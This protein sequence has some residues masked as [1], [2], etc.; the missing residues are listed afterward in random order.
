ML[1]IFQMGKRSN[2]LGWCWIRIEDQKSLVN[3]AFKAHS[4]LKFHSQ[5]FNFNGFFIHFHMMKSDE[6]LSSCSRDHIDHRSSQLIWKNYFREFLSI[7][8][9]SKCRLDKTKKQKS[10]VHEVNDDEQPAH[11]MHTLNRERN[12]S[13][14]SRVRCDTDVNFS[15]R[16]VEET[17][18]L[19]INWIIRRRIKR[20]FRSRVQRSST[21]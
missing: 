4:T 3:E 14:H 9:W 1:L 21:N 5:N 20:Q 17:W 7:K 10:G 19:K 13:F 2:A 8:F 15:L 12:F 11:S 16:A 6:K 18:M